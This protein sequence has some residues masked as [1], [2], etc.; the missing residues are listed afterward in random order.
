MTSASLLRKTAQSVL[1]EQVI[2]DL[3]S[4]G[5]RRLVAARLPLEVPRGTAVQEMPHPP[6]QEADARRVYPEGKKWEDAGMHSLRF[7]ALYCVV[8]GEADLAMGVTTSMLGALSPQHR[9]EAECGGYIVSLKAPAYFLIPPGV[10]YRTTPPWQRPEPHT[11]TLRLF[12]VRVLPIGAL[13]NITTMQEGEY[14]IPYSLLVKDNQL[15]SAMELLVDELNTPPADMQI[16]QAQ[17]LTLMLRLKRRMSTQLPLLT[18]GIYSRFPESEPTDRQAQPLHQPI[19]ER[20]HEYIQLH[21]HETLT[22]R[23]IAAQV[24]LTPDHLNRIF[25][26]NTGVSLMNYATRQRME[27]AQLLLR[28]SELSVREVSSLVGYR[29]LPHFSRTFLQYTGY[30]PLKFRQQESEKK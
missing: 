3:Q 6:L 1:Q 28:T 22:A 19:V 12:I 8:E 10:P 9:P 14:A 13:C 5:T 15:A 2:P 23:E 29:Q 25:K 30:S 4:G 7:P 18:D 20:V 21:L 11:G 27:S 26:N 16:V 17:L 24:Q